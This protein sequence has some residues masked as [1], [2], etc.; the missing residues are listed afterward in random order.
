MVTEFDVLAVYAQAVGRGRAAVGSEPRVSDVMMRPVETVGPSTSFEEAAARC[1]ELQVHHLPVVDAGRL[2]GLLSDRDLRA[3]AGN[4]LPGET[5][6]AEIMSTE[7]VT[8]SPND[9]A[10]QV[11]RQ[12]I[13]NRFS[14]VPVV[15]AG[16]LV[17]LVT[18]TDLLVFA[19]RALGSDDGRGAESDG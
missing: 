12:L 4:G 13:S 1:R 8:V 3:A 6:V 11:A 19:M 7:L 10:A 17:G 14:S 9:G 15:E 16:R 2:V 18:V 5:P